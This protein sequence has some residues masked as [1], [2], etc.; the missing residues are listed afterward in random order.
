[1]AP[2]PA[3]LPAAGVGWGATNFQW[4]DGFTAAPNST[5]GYSN[6]GAGLPDNAGNNASATVHQG[7]T[8]ARR[9]SLQLGVGSWDDANC[10]DPY[11]AIC[12]QM[13]GWR[14]RRRP[15]TRLRSQGLCAALL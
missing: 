10:T 7:C 13:R 11:L 15:C 9:N 14:A 1:M 5:G 8:I 4:V 12:K 3:P 6:W 2:A